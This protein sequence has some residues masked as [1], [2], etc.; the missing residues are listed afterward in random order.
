[1]PDVSPRIYDIKGEITKVGLG[2]LQNSVTKERFKE[3]WP[4]ARLAEVTTKEKLFL[5]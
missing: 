3:T 2:F 4:S 1:M 5:V